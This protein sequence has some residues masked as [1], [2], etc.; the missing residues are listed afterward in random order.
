MG[1]NHHHGQCYIEIRRVGDQSHGDALVQCP[2]F[3][4][5]QEEGCKEAD[6]EHDGAQKSE[7]VHGLLAKCS[8]EPQRHQVEI[9]V[10]KTV[11]AHELR[12]A[13]LALLVVYGL[14][15]NLVETSILGQI[16]DEAVHL[17]EHLDILD[18]LTAIGFQATVEV[19][20][21]LDAADLARSGVEELC[22][23]G[24]RQ[25]VTLA[26]V[27]LVATDKVV[28]LVDN[29]VVQARYLVGRVLQVCVHRDDNVAYSLLETTE[30]GRA[31]AVVA[32]KLDALHVLRLLGKFCDDVPRAVGRTIVDED[33]FIR[34]LVL[35]HHALYPRKEFGD[36]LVFV[37]K[38]YYY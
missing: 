16:G 30:Q 36:R 33:D 21:V 13:V 3:L 5:T 31:L 32:A 15:A 6:D 38:R 4:C 17:A 26:A 18:D 12:L 23:D 22:G 2:R 7:D 8:E 34:K 25:G 20:Q 29:H 19:V 14:L 37:I 28:L 1:T 27:L 24:L 9:A 11:P 10:D 35:R